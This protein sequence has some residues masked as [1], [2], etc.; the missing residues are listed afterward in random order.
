M[1]LALP[2]EQSRYSLQW[3]SA[4]S[5]DARSLPVEAFNKITSAVSRL[6][7]DPR[8]PNAGAKHGPLRGLLGIAVGRFRI[9][10]RVDD[11]RRLVE[12]L[13]IRDRKEVYR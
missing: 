1:Q 2:V 8:P 6:I 10:Y 3:L 7:F 9:L 5:K 11:A 13:R 4:A 12:V